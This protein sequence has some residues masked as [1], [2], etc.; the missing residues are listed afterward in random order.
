MRGR[1]EDGEVL[2]NLERK[3]GRKGER[4]KGRKRK[5]ERKSY[6]REI[7]KRIY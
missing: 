2:S 1:G 7:R 3:D 5:K 6:L 4:R